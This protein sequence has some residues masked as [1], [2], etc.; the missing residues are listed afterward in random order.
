MTKSA[1]LAGLAVATL[2][3]APPATADDE[4][5]DPTT[6]ATCTPLT[7]A[8]RRELGLARAATVRY[9]DLDQAL[10][11]G[12]VDIDVVIPNM[13][14]HFLNVALLDGEFDPERPEIL[15]YARMPNGRLRLVAVE[16]AV[17]LALTDVAPEGF[18]GEAD[19]WHAQ[20]VYGLWTLHAWLWKRNP[21]GIFAETNARVP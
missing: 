11:D 7:R 18:A 4:L 5:F 10:A 21:A 14:H 17:P 13:G 6:A 20:E 19:S 3:L 1:A 15:V 2:L 12:Y 16:Y 9:Q 8:A